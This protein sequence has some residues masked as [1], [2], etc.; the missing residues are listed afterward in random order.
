MI[1]LV[2]CKQ[3]VPDDS[4]AKLEAMKELKNIT[5]EPVKKE[6][7]KEIKKEVVKEFKSTKCTHNTNCTFKKYCIAGECK[8][9][10]DF[11]EKKD[12]EK[13]CNYQKIKITTGDGEKYTLSRGQG[14]YTAASALEWTI[15]S[16]PDYCSGEI[17]KVPFK[18]LK[19]NY[20][21]VFADEVV[22][23]KVGETSKTIG[24]PLMP[25][26]AFTLR[27]ESVDESCG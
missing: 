15:V 6:V 12:C 22:I 24:H 2:G 27:V 17:I 1:T 9:I 4:P 5:E 18:I 13:K 7:K 19:R 21:K 10:A 11:Y 25:E 26:I 16:G 3:L 8:A 23:L 20:G 14:S